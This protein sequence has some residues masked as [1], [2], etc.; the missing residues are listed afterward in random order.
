MEVAFEPC[1]QICTDLIRGRR[2][3]SPDGAACLENSKHSGVAGPVSAQRDL[4]IQ[5]EVQVKSKFRFNNMV[6]KSYRI[7]WKDGIELK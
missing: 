3:C 1:R 7:V 6:S 2:A 4:V 5:L